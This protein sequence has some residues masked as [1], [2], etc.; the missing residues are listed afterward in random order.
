[1]KAVLEKARSHLESQGETYFQHMYGAWKIIYLLK[2]LE[3]KCLIHSIVPGL[4]TEAVSEKIECLQKM[5]KRAKNE[6][7]T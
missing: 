1:M 2:T 3:L 4:Y 5:T 7:P 6:T